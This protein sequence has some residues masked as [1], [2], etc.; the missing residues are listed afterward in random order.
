VRLKKSVAVLFSTLLALGAVISV[1]TSA[2]AATP[3]CNS[4]LSM[5]GYLGGG[6]YGLAEVPSYGTNTGCLLSLNANTGTDPGKSPVYWLQYNLNKCYGRS[7][8]IDGIYGAKTVAAVKYAQSTVPGLAQD[9]AYGPNTRSAIKW[10][11]EHTGAHGAVTRAC[12]SFGS[13]K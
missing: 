9:G 8:A 1:G 7:L 2:Q 6:V 4:R 12:L 3:K 10:D 11:T 13:L 5:T